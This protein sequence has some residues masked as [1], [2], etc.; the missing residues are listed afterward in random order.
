MQCTPMNCFACGARSPLFGGATQNGAIG[1][2]YPGQFGFWGDVR[3][4]LTCSHLAS[5]SF[6]EPVAASAGSLRACLSHSASWPHPLRSAP[7]AGAAS[8]QRRCCA[9]AHRPRTEHGVW[10]LASHGSMDEQ[11]VGRMR[12]SLLAPRH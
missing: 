9:P 11:R 8:N 6:Q 7:V 5:W 4:P 1:S 10:E 3:A 12:V 2:A